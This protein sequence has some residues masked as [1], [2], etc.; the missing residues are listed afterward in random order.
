MY[1]KLTVR[2]TIRQNWNAFFNKIKFQKIKL[3]QP[4]SNA[5]KDFII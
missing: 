3:L 1:N 4:N 5:P 2:Q